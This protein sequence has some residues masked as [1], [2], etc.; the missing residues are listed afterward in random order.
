MSSLDKL[1]KNFKQ[2]N[3]KPSDSTIA[4]SIN[5]PL[6]ALKHLSNFIKNN[7]DK[8]MYSDNPY[9][10]VE[11]AIN[12]A[13]L[14]QTGGMPFAPSGSGIVGSILS[15]LSKDYSEKLANTAKSMLEKGSNLSEIWKATKM[16]PWETAKGQKIM[17][18]EIPDINAK[19]LKPMSTK[20]SLKEF[21][22][23][24]Q[25]YDN[26]PYLESVEIKPQNTKGSYLSSSM[27]T[28]NDV[29]NIGTNH[30]NSLKT[31]LHELTHS[32]QEHNGTTHEF[33]LERL[34]DELDN[35]DNFNILQNIV[36]INNKR[37]NNF[38]TNP[39]KEI[40]QSAAHEA[41]ARMI[42]NR[43]NKSNKSLENI[44]PID[45]LIK[46]G[47]DPQSLLYDSTLNKLK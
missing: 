19:L 30:Q 12:I 3:F 32:I 15:P 38:Q 22:S 21:L 8:T 36:G 10:Q 39:Y 9:A 6:N 11:G 41:Q 18:S 40:Y 2:S 29:V 23:H 27:S 35:P 5:H 42:E 13:G 43:L 31:L 44:S 7:M 17:L 25:L 45:T 33:G 4:S 34:S 28:G 1:V 16:Y 14:A 46:M 37:L 26:Y 24:Q 47:Y 20:G